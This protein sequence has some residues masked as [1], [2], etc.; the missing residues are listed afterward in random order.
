V[1]RYR[2]RLLG[3]VLISI[4]ICACGEVPAIVTPTPITTCDPDSNLYEDRIS[5]QLNNIYDQAVESVTD[6]ETYNISRQKAFKELV[7]YVYVLSSTA[8]IDS[9][10]KKFRVTITYVSPEIAQLIVI[11]HYL[12]KGII[13]YKGEL[14]EQIKTQISGL[15]HR[16]EHV[17]FITFIALQQNDGLTIK[18]P[19][20][21]FALTNTN[22]LNI[23]P[24]HYD[25]NL[26]R[27]ILIN[28]EPE[29][30]FFYF[31]MAVMK[32]VTCQTVLDRTYDTRV[33]LNIPNI[34]IDDKEV[35]SRFWEYKYAPL[36][37]MTTIS[38]EHQYNFSIKQPVNQIT[39]KTGPFS[40]LDL[41]SESYWI[42]IA[43]MLWMEMTLDP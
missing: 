6:I 34:W 23:Q 17:F 41:E 8:D 21:E 36:I 12:Y 25:Q 28:N 30:G 5:D 14:K 33:R 19:I 26:G 1:N 40:S 22:N 32:N 29:Y 20:N 9:D 43:R 4:L 2:K 37:D 15:I 7:N 3:V 11:N 39:P 42:S 35:G 13:K 38:P 27:P 16:N 31:P 18:I 10:G 24:I